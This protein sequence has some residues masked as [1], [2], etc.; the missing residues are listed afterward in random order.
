M[1]PSRQERRRTPASNS[2]ARN[3][4]RAARISARATRSARSGSSAS[5]VDNLVTAPTIATDPSEG[6]DRRSPNPHRRRTRRARRPGGV[7]M[8][9]AM[10]GP[11]RWLAQCGGWPSAVV[12]PVRWLV[13]CDGCAG[14]GPES[15]RVVPR[16]RDS[17][18][19]RRRATVAGAGRPSRASG[20]GRKGGGRR[21]LPSF[22]L[23]CPCRR[24]SPPARCTLN[25]KHCTMDGF[26]CTV[27]AKRCTR[28]AKWCTLD[29]KRCT[30]DA[31]GYLVQKSRSG[32]MS[33]HLSAQ[34][35][36]PD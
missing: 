10:V 2:A 25:E 34:S 14:H 12:G 28:D 16:Q 6:H 17:G 24:R 11:V 36:H 3:L 33:I 13:Q 7:A 15:R 19:P 4:F 35:I 23:G 20:P 32:C 1:V 5:A 9:S 21:F 26:T 27:D 22:R 29:A 8:S 18:I 31:A 30:L